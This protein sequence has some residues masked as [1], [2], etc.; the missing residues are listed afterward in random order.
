MSAE[1]TCIRQSKNDT[2][3]NNE[4]YEEASYELRTS[5]NNSNLNMMR[6][7]GGSIGP[8]ALT[9]DTNEINM[10]INEGTDT[11]S[12]YKTYRNR[13][14]KYIEIF[15]EHIVYKDHPIN[16]VIQIFE[17]TWV[18]YINKQILK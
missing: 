3:I 6:A 11:D 18:K 15:K 5:I 17:K 13:V 4:I 14:K 7:L 2:S 9:E 8:N 1:P 12:K 10:S 16:K